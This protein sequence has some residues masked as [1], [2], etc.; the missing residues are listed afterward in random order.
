MHI[1]ITTVKIEAV[2]IIF[3]SLI[4]AFIMQTCHNRE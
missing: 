2:K 3:H 1:H 4:H